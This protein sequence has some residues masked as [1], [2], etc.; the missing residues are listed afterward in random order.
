MF[1]IYMHRN[2]INKKVYIGITSREPHVR[3]G[4]NGNNY[5]RHKHF[6]SA[7]KKYGWDNFEHKILTT[8]ESKE[9]A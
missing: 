2:K 5:N 9:E 4:K 3:W 8:V 7:I 1:F 6:Y